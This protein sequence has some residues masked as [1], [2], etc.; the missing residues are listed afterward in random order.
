M[1]STEKGPI[2]RRATVTNRT[3]TIGTFT[4]SP[5]L[6]PEFKTTSFLERSV[7]TQDPH[8]E[9]SGFVGL[10]MDGFSLAG[11]NT[12]TISYYDLS[13]V[14]F[15]GGF[16]ATVPSVASNFTSGPTLPTPTG[17]TT[18]YKM[19]GYYTTGLVY[20]SFVTTGN[21]TSASTT[22]PNTGH[23]L[24]NTFVTQTWTSS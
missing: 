17:V 7:G 18:Y 22:N 8:D 20:E 13:T 24:V 4:V 1:V 10:K 16:A 6:P 15:S 23:A 9:P 2:L 5:G 21:P 19:V 14:P 12:H 3:T 11:L